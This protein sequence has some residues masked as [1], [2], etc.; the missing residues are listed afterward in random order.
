MSFGGRSR[1]ITDFTDFTYP[2]DPTAATRS[3]VHGQL[4]RRRRQHSPISA[5]VKR[6]HAIA[7][8][9]SHLASFTALNRPEPRFNATQEVLI[10][11]LPLIQ[12]VALDS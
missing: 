4:P 7:L 10:L 5:K 8:L 9:A 2:D 11:Y 6:F 1:E 3:L 12:E